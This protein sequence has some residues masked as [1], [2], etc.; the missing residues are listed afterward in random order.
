MWARKRIDIDWKD[1]GWGM[2]WS[3]WSG[4]TVIA[5][6]RLEAAWG[7]CEETLATLSVRSGFDLLLK[8]LQL[9]TGS[10]VVLSAVTIQ[11]MARIIEA[12]DM[13]PVPVDLD[14]FTM[15]PS[16]QA[17]ESAISDKTKLILIAHLFGGI[18]DLAPYAE[19]A[20]KH[21]IPLIEDCAQ[22]FDGKR[23]QGHPKTDVIMFSFGPIKT[24][25]ALAGGLMT[26][27]DRG[28]L[29]QMRNRQQTYPVQSQCV[30]RKRVLTY[31]AMNFI[32]GY[33]P[34]RIFVRCCQL[35]GQD[36]ESLLNGAVRNFPA[37]KFFEA[38]R[39]QPSAS[40]C[41]MMDRRIRRFDRRRQDR[42]TVSGAKLH[43]LLK[44][45]YLCPG[46]G[47]P[48]HSTWVFP[49]VIPNSKAMSDRF[50]EAGFDVATASQLRP[51]HP[52]SFEEKA[53]P[54]QAAAC[55]EKTVY[56]PFYPEMTDKAIK[57]MAAI[58]KQ[59]S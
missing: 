43:Q 51:I 22:A 1:L 29:K 57:Q 49:I 44:D 6:S 4:S 26:V 52:P 19:I 25:T 18:I 12:H 45:H 33:F 15:A 5:S 59:E 17:L 40:L 13:I 9:P 27:R 54:L 10:E 56:L 55:L 39:Q 23:Y 35:L 37:D 11:D 2:L 16:P 58:L 34:F 30:Y 46:R 28:L 7:K 50:K 3:F 53:Q 32:G 21:G 42:R 38:L 36:C 8:E 48:S 14:P 31:A 24:A 41:K 20:K 47:L